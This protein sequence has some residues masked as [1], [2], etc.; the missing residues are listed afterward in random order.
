M[1]TL[2]LEKK[3]KKNQLERL[4]DKIKNSKQAIKA[5]VQAGYLRI[6]V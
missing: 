4:N 3:K 2:M 1:V 6:K 5:E